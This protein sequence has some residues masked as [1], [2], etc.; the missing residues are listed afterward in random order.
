MGDSWG[1]YMAYKGGILASP[2]DP[3]SSTLQ[4]QAANVFLNPGSAHSSN[5]D[6]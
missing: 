1:Y 4:P 6:L 5:L 3:P 2:F